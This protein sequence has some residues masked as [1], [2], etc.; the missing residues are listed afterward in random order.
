MVLE[1]LRESVEHMTGATE[2]KTMQAVAK[3]IGK[4]ADSLRAAIQISDSLKNAKTKLLLQ[5]METF[6]PS[7]VTT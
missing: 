2:E 3:E 6:P 7:E 4:S 5:V 1:Q